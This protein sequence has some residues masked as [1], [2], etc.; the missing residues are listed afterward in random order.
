MSDETMHPLFYSDLFIKPNVGTKKQR[1][2]LLDKINYL[3]KNNIDIAS[4]SNVGCFRT[5][6]EYGE[7][8]DWLR[9]EI[10]QFAQE[11][12]KF[13]VSKEPILQSLMTEHTQ[14]IHLSM[15][16]NVNEPGSTNDLHTHKN[17]NFA[18]TYNLQT[19]GTGNL[20]F[21]NPANLLNDC[22]QKSPYIRDY[23]IEPKDGDL[24]IWPAWVPHYVEENKSNKQRINIATNIKLVDKNAIIINEGG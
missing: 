12:C 24:L 13:Y 15:W 3:K 1:K 18:C 9:E 6:Y 17:A 8:L 20:V 5:S 19:E 23:K 4:G 10:G 14:Q 21:K 7:E 22:N 11:I 16:T 2:D